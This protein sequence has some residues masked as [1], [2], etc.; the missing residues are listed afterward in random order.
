MSADRL[1]LLWGVT[2][3]TGA[4]A[5][6]IAR[7]TSL[8]G[9]VILLASGLIVGRAGF[10]WIEPLDLG[11][12]LGT[13]VGL[14]VSLVLFDGGLNLR[15]PGGELKNAVLRIVLVRFV[16]AL[17]AGLIAAHWLAGLNWPLAAVFSAIVLATGPTVVNPLVQQMRLR[18]PPLGSCLKGKV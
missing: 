10:H 7:L 11:S 5:Q 6:L 2:I 4:S 18:P 13:V 3:A 17:I 15:L 9:V 14:L 16:V 8:P 12:S 1:G